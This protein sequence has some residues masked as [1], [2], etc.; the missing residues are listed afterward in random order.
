MAA[1][2]L[3][4]VMAGGEVLVL[5]PSLSKWEILRRPPAQQSNQLPL[6]TK[7]SLF[8]LPWKLLIKTV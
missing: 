2:S 8:F 6:Q 4:P 7:H 3:G 1:G 5:V